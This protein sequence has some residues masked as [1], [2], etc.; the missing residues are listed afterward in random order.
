MATTAQVWDPNLNG[1]GQG[2][3][4]TS[5]PA[6]TPGAQFQTGVGDIIPPGTQQML[7]GMDMGQGQQQQN[8]SPTPSIVPVDPNQP[9]QNLGAAA[10]GQLAIYNP[11]PTQAGN[12]SG[13]G[14]VASP[15]LSAT[16][17]TAPQGPWT[18]A[19]TGSLFAQNTAAANL[20]P[21][22]PW[23]TTGGP[24]R[25][26]GA[27]LNPTPYPGGTTYKAPTP[28]A[29][30]PPA[31]GITAPQMNAAPMGMGGGQGGGMPMGGGGQPQPNPAMNYTAGSTG[32]PPAAPGT[33]GWNGDPDIHPTGGPN[34]TRPGLSHP[35]TYTPSGGG[36]TP[37]AQTALKT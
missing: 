34:P 11:T 31:P 35:L 36:G 23:S 15:S 29:T 8:N 2:G 16:V 14:K 18:N 28:Y 20:K 17:P 30:P 33:G 27:A 5:A 3:W 13:V 7:N 4:A 12:V 10:L 22:K 26:P 24:A 32:L 6:G 9:T 21:T 37:A 1:P 19:P 25:N